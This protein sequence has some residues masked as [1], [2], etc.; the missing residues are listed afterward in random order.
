MSSSHG[1]IF[2]VGEQ[3]IFFHVFISISRKLQEQTTK[4]KLVLKFVKVWI[5]IFKNDIEMLGELM[6]EQKKKT[7]LLF[8]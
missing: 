1:G 8:Y 3:L 4:A 2:K 5:Y 7:Y 6:E